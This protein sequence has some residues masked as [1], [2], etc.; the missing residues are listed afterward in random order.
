LPLPLI[1]TFSVRYVHMLGS[2]QPRAVYR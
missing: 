2:S 1:E